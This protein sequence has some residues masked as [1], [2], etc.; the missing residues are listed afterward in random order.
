M[1]LTPRM[2]IAIAVAA[3]AVSATATAGIL[4]LRGPA[5]TL[6]EAVELAEQPSWFSRLPGL[7]LAEVMQFSNHFYFEYREVSTGRYA[8]EMLMD[9]YSGRM[10]PEMGPNMMW[11]TKYGSSMMGGMMGGWQTNASTA[12]MP[13]SPEQAVGLAN[14]Y[15]DGSRPGWSATEPAA[16]YGYY[17]LHVESA[18]MV[19]GMLSVHGTS[20]AV[21]YHSWH[22]TF[23]DMVEFEGGM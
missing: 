3:L 2:A 17:T 16:F 8:V 4:L 13:I 10:S 12:P 11:N 23:V 20:G 1:L 22:G 5:L 9:R 15:L 19:V 18:G 6:T 7:E 14:A 21:W